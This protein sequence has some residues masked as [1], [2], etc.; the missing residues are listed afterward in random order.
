[1]MGDLVAVSDWRRMIGQFQTW[2]D[3]LAIPI[4]T[5]APSPIFGKKTRALSTH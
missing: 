1:M 4:F 2:F 5:K 3:A